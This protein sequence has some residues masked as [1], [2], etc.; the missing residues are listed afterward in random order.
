[1]PTDDYHREVT[2]E[3]H[4]MHHDIADVTS[5][6]ANQPDLLLHRAGG[7][8]WIPNGYPWY[9]NI[10]QYMKIRDVDVTVPGDR[11]GAASRR[12][13]EGREIPP[14]R[15]HT[16]ATRLQWSRAPADIG[17]CKR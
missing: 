6:Y 7:V 9:I 17:E 10:E 15:R 3:C 12:T 11:D 13:G 16:T 1:M 8:M 5:L 4:R 14:H 2:N